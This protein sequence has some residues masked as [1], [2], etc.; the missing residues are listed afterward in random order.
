M[1]IGLRIGPKSM[2]CRILDKVKNVVCLG[3]MVTVAVPIL[4]YICWRPPVPKAQVRR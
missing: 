4:I 3:L 2:R 1:R